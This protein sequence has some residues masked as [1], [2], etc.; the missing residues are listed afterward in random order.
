MFNQA[1]EGEMREKRQGTVNNNIMRRRWFVI[2]VAVLFSL[3][4]VITVLV[5]FNCHCNPVCTVTLVG[6]DL[7]HV[8]SIRCKQ[9]LHA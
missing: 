7:V 4:A 8:S 3:F 2:G 1:K 5:S 6:P 9:G